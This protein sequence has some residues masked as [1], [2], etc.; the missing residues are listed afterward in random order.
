MDVRLLR[1]H[2]NYIRNSAD[3]ICDEDEVSMGGGGALPNEI[4][5]RQSLR[6]EMFTTAA[7]VQ[8]SSIQNILYYAKYIRRLRSEPRS[9][10]IL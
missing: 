4:L 5:S 7:C 1:K 6:L 2:R 10:T 3:R 9:N 8:Y